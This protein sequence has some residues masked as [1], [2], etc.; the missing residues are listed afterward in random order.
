MPFFDGRESRGE[1]SRSGRWP[2][3]SS[4]RWLTH[5]LPPSNSLNARSTNVRARPATSDSAG[6][7][8]NDSIRRMSRQASCNDVNACC[9][10]LATESESGRIG[11][12][13]GP[14]VSE[15]ALFPC[16]NVVCGTPA[17]GTCY[18]RVFVL[19]T[20]FQISHQPG[21]KRQE[22]AFAGVLGCTENEES[23]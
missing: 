5:R 14:P 7:S 4:A 3:E 6:S 21:G 16:S 12:L 2:A 15:S 18:C 1:W 8:D 20:V 11:P 10:K 9:L 17:S 13:V 22:Y 23:L 19:L